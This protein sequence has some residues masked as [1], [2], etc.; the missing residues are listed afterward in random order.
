MPAHGLCT[1]VLGSAGND[2]QENNWY[3][4]IQGTSGDG[5]W[6]QH[7]NQNKVYGSSEYNQGVGMNCTT[8]CVGNTLYLDNESNLVGGDPSQD[9][10]LT[11]NGSDNSLVN[12]LTTGQVYI[13][14]NRNRVEGGTYHQL[15]IVAGADST[16]LNGPKIDSFLADNGTDTIGGG[17]VK[18]IHADSTPNV[19]QPG[20][21]PIGRN[22]WLAT[23]N[24]EPDTLQIVGGGI[25]TLNAAAYK[26]IRAYSL[27]LATFANATISAGFGA[28]TGSTPHGLYMNAQGG[29]NPVLYVWQDTAWVSK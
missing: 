18:T 10:D 24:D 8:T 23:G 14:G 6:L 20:A 21:I 4:A 5:M 15:T 25:N 29:A 13:Y 22:V 19:R 7:F 9:V 11:I 1:D 3:V 26:N 12:T 28:P 27:Q 16:L 17:T 2:V